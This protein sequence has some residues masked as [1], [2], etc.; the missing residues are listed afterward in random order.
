MRKL[1]IL[2]IAFIAFSTDSYSQSA[3]SISFEIGGPGVASLNFDTRL[4]NREDGIGAR[5]GFGGFSLNIDDD[6]HSL[7]FVPIGVNYLLGKDKRNYFEIGAG[8]TPV[9]YDGDSKDDMF[10]TSFGHI[11]FGYRLQPA[12][13]GFTFRGF[14]SP[15]VGGFGFY[16]LYG[17]VSL[18][19]K[20]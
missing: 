16:P 8:F 14:I 19:Y 20:F 12:N 2:A 7:F 13:G 17:G 5:V 11:L 15:I 3:K 4:G 9:I 1:F 6:R 10:T 18:G